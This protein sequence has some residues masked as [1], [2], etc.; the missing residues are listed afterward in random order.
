MSDWDT[1][2]SLATAGGTLVLAV[3]TFAAVRSGTGRPQWRPCGTDR[4]APAAG[5]AAPA[6][7][8][9]AAAG[10]DQKS[11]Y[12]TNRRLRIS[13]PGVSTPQRGWWTAAKRPCGY[14]PDRHAFACAADCQRAI[15][16]SPRSAGTHPPAKMAP[17]LLMPPGRGRYE[18]WL[19]AARAR[20]GPGSGVHA[21]LCDRSTARRRPASQSGRGFHAGKLPALIRRGAM[22]EHHAQAG[23][24]ADQRR[25]GSAPRRSWSMVG[26]LWMYHG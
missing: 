8:D 20:P 7:G 22:Q 19:P 17:A 18:C 5:R 1:A 4:G 12:R 2:A 13:R 23:H 9:L 10:P 11:C 16:L 25:S 21:D 14:R 3:A 26:P 15:R 24:E 6:C